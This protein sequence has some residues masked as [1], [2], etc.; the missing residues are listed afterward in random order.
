ME[1]FVQNSK[2]NRQILSFSGWSSTQSDLQRL[3]LLRNQI[4]PNR[5]IIQPADRVR[6]WHHV[7]N[8]VLLGRKQFVRQWIRCKRVVDKRASMRPPDYGFLAQPNSKHGGNGGIPAIEEGVGRDF[9]IIP[10]EDEKS[11]LTPCANGSESF[12][13]NSDRISPDCKQCFH[14]KRKLADASHTI[15]P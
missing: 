14:G 3:R 11:L 12:A 10:V 5:L 7:A 6:V 9:R 1:R 13:V 8:P 2:S 4:P 15:W